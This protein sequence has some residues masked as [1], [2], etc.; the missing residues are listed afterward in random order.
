MPYREQGWSD[1]EVSIECKGDAASGFT[2]ASSLAAKC[3]PNEFRESGLLT[4]ARVR[5]GS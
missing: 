3:L 5:A 1:D 4:P 2:V